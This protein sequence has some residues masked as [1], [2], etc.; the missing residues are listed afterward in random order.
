MK[1]ELNYTFF[2]INAGLPAK[3]VFNQPPPANWNFAQDQEKLA[4]TSVPT[5]EISGNQ[6]EMADVK[7]EIIE[8]QK[9]SK[10]RTDRYNLSLQ[11]LEA[12]QNQMA[13]DI[14]EKFALLLQKMNE[15]KKYDQKVQDIV[16]R[17]N[18]LLKGYEV[19]LNQMQKLL[20]QKEQDY[21][22]AVTSLK[23]LKAEIGRLKRL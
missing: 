4:L 8:I 9:A 11:R 12:Q 10:L 5:P 22:E 16:D 13:N 20:M 3:P 1:K 6:N 23:E 19:R 14:S 18:N 7:M 17:H 21:V 2:D 15:Q